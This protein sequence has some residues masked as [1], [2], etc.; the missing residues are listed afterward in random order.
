VIITLY[1]STSDTLEVMH[2]LRAD[3]FMLSDPSYQPASQMDD[4]GN[5]VYTGSFFTE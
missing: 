2:N 5:L 3:A 1:T 4:A